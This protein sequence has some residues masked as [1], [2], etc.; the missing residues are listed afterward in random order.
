M[1]EL[2]AIFGLD[3]VIGIGDNERGF[4]EDLFFVDSVVPDLGQVRRVIGVGEGPA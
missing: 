1:G 3:F 4:S 2:N